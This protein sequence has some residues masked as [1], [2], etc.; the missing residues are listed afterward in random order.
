MLWTV[1]GSDGHTGQSALHVLSTVCEMVQ[2]FQ[3]VTLGGQMTA[4]L[5][6]CSMQEEGSMQ[7]VQEGV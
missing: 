2:S 1:L 6:G 3:E 7:L 5:P 4:A